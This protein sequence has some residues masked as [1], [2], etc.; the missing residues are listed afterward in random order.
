[1]K[2]FI[3]RR[4]RAASLALLAAVLAV[5]GIAS[6]Q[7]DAATKARGGY[8]WGN[9]ATGELAD[10]STIGRPTPVASTGLAGVSTM[11]AG[12][13]HNLALRSDGTKLFDSGVVRGTGGSVGVYADVTGVQTLKLVVGDGG[14][15]VDNDHADWGN[16]RLA[17]S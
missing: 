10:G 9:N 3:H 2:R 15:G 6:F 7:A 4:R 11:S 1:M 16:P 5:A 12:M 17:C 13:W 14:D 8:A